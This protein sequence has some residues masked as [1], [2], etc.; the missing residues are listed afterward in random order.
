M[1][2][3][4]PI[5]ILVV[6]DDQSMLV[7]LSEQVRKCG[8]EPVTANTWAGA[9]QL[10]RSSDPKVVL[11]D[12]MMP[13]IDGF[14]LARIVK[15]E[16]D[17]FVPVILITGLNDRESKQRGMAAGADDLLTKPVGVVDLQVRLDSMLRIQ[18]LTD[19][20][21][22]AKDRLAEMAVTDPLTSL[23]NRRALVE[24]LDR[25]FSRSRRYDSP[26]SVFMLDIDWFKRINDT[27]G[28]AVGDDVLVLV[29]EILRNTIRQ[30]DV[31]GRYGGEEFMVVAAETSHARAGA[32]AERLR[33]RVELESKRV[34]LP[35]VTLSIG[36]A[37]TDVCRETAS[38]QDLVDL[39]DEAL[40]Q[41][42]RTGRN[43]CVHSRDP[44]RV[45]E[46][47]EF[48]PEETQPISVEELGHPTLAVGP[49][50]TLPIDLAELAAHDVARPDD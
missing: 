16:S 5:R 29:S 18:R 42:K 50:E 33:A 25:E 34:D 48:L 37:S 1:S 14:K 35:A 3:S 30:S 26:F 31:V 23:G 43:R 6:D 4:E 40:Y 24:Q 49:E 20:L 2:N 15:E 7:A 9:L 21:H 8:Y 46:G 10:F 38:V 19:Q 11:L 41:A 45:T 27:H 36:V 32:L 17:R 13:T 12:V 44:N 28:H 47:S 39:A 22:E